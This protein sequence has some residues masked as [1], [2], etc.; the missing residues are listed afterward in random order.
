MVQLTVPNGTEE[1]RRGME[2]FIQWNDNL[3][4]DVAIEL[5]KGGALIQT[6]A[7]VPS[8]G[9]YKWE[10]DLTLEPGADYSIRI[11]SATDET[12]T[13]VSDAAFTIN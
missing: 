12:M 5:H 8:T 11:K 13:D 2:Y 9:A 6:I 3:A 10:V 4:E 7:T 1:W